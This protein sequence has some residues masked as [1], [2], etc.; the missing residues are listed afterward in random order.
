[1][2]AKF[3]LEFSSAF[4][5]RLRVTG[6][7]ECPRSD[8]FAF[9]LTLSARLLF[10]SKTNWIFPD[11]RGQVFKKEVRQI[12]F[13]KKLYVPC[14]IVVKNSETTS[15]KLFNTFLAVNCILFNF[16]HISKM[17]LKFSPEN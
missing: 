2:L 5:R 7:Q 12:K 4:L 9:H 16:R 17:P 11:P 8:Q 6:G 3:K 10:V 14:V 13:I 1:M 15:S